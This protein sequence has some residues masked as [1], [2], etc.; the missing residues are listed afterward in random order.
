M[1]IP[2]V[3]GGSTQEK[4][5]APRTLS[6]IFNRNRVVFGQLDDDVLVRGGIMKQPQAKPSKMA[7]DPVNL[8]M[9]FR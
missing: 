1:N 5:N 6:T 8:H 2:C 7:S 9:R 4:E 3:P